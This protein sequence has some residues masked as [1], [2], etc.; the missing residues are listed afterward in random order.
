MTFRNVLT[1]THTKNPANTQ[2]AASNKLS[3]DQE[4]HLDCNTLSSVLGLL[5]NKLT[6]KLPEMV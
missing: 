1:H 3:S 6:Q 5:H 4:M 2:N